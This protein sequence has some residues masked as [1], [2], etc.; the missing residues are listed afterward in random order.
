M[1]KEK[2]NK[3]NIAEQSVQWKGERRNAPLHHSTKQTEVML[4]DIPKSAIEISLSPA[5]SSPCSSAG[6]ALSMRAVR[7]FLTSGDESS[8]PRGRRKGGGVLEGVV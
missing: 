8:M 5:L 1:L 2:E 4:L 6:M 3:Q 7:R